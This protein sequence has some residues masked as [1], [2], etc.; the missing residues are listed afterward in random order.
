[1][2]ELQ[3]AKQQLPEQ[4]R[5]PQIVLQE[6]LQ[7]MGFEVQ[8]ACVEESERILFNILG[9]EARLLIGKKGQTLDALQFLLNK[10]VYRDGGAPKVLVVDSGGYRQR[11]EESL[12]QLALRLCEKAT[13]T[14]K[15]IAVNP[16]SAHDRRI[17]HMALKETPGVST[18]SEGEG[19][20]RRLLIV[21]EE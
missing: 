16:M 21:P 19:I 4:A 2:E 8:V 7:F 6:I 17:I 18:R 10:I 12:V 11:R 5:D 13:R 15:I 3:D 1:M 14:G 20:F 9:Q